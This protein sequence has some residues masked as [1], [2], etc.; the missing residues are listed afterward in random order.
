MTEELDFV[1]LGSIDKKYFEEKL[2]DS[3]EIKEED[4]KIEKFSSI[5]KNRIYDLILTCEYFYFYLRKETKDLMAFS[6]KSKNGEVLVRV[7]LGGKENNKSFIALND[8][9]SKMDG[10]YLERVRSLAKEIYSR[11]LSYTYSE[12]SRENFWQRFFRWCLG[13]PVSFFGEP[14]Y[15]G[16]VLAEEFIF[17]RKIIKIIDWEDSL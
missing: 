1:N 16:D 5:S 7:I 6:A 17:G 12:E 13:E 3:L 2:L 8:A 9:N 11:Y 10:D 14:I 15:S 4:D